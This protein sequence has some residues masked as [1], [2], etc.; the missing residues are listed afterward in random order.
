[1]TSFDGRTE[2][3]ENGLEQSLVRLDAGAIPGHVHLSEEKHLERPTTQRRLQ[4][5][6]HTLPSPGLVPMDAGEGYG[7]DGRYTAAPLA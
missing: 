2:S 6:E 1:M 3:G 7:R 5:T 4:A